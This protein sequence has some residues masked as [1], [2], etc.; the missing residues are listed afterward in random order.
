[1]FTT[2]SIWH[3][4]SSRVSLST[5]LRLNTPSILAHW[6]FSTLICRALE[7]L[8][9]MKDQSSSEYWKTQPEENQH[10]LSIRIYIHFPRWNLR[11]C[12]IPFLPGEIRL[13]VFYKS[14]FFMFIVT[15]NKHD[16]FRMECPKMSSDLCNI[17]LLLVVSPQQLLS[18]CFKNQMYHYRIAL[19]NDV[20]SVL[21]IRQVENWSSGLLFGSF[22]LLLGVERLRFVLNS[23]VLE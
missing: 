22:P 20:V 18:V 2:H 10:R 11:N 7:I 15:I 4:P 14:C 9:S 12:I 13:R 3:A 16:V 17:H 1:M 19:Y 21:Y 23:Q 6:I 8:T 5:L